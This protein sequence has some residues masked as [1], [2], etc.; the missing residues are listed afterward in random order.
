MMRWRAC[1]NAFQCSIRRRALLKLAVKTMSPP[2]SLA[3]AKSPYPL[4]PETVAMV[5]PKQRFAEHD[6]I[7]FPAE[8]QDGR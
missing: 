4:T 3:M 2:V 8:R 6:P 1:L 7:P 5:L